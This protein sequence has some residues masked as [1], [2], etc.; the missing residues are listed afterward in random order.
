VNPPR[1]VVSAPEGNRDLEIRPSPADPLVFVDDSG[2]RIRWWSGLFIIVM[3][4]LVAL[5]VL[6][7]I[8]VVQPSRKVSTASSA[9]LVASP[10]ASPAAVVNPPSSE[11]APFGT[12]CEGVNGVAFIDRDLNGARTPE[13]TGVPDVTVGAFDTNNQR[14]ASTVTGADGT[15]SLVFS[16]ATQVRLEFSLPGESLMFGPA[17][18]DSVGGIAF[19]QQPNC[20]VSVGVNGRGVFP[21]GTPA[22]MQL[23]GRLWLDSNCDGRQGP[24]EGGLRR[25]ALELSDAS[26]T[27]LA[28]AL[29]DET[30]RYVF[31]GIAQNAIYSVVPVRSGDSTDLSDLHPTVLPGKVSDKSLGRGTLEL[32]DASGTPKATAS[33]AELGQSDF[34]LSFGYARRGT[35]G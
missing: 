13:E 22:M 11:V 34:R 7:A 30:G 12:Y 18:L 29:T 14:L 31:G 27:V 20:E 8:A 35:C 33:L 2:R 17:G 1:D 15:Y 4:S 24:D 5:F 23:G 16:A 21:D 6:I 32:V 3:A 10:P 26:G 25:V 28:T 9:K 19:P